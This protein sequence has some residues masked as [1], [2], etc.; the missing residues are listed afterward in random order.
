MCDS[1]LENLL[2]NHKLVIINKSQTCF[3]AV[4]TPVS[5]RLVLKMIHLLLY[6]FQHHGRI[7]WK[8]LKL[9]IL[10]MKV[11]MIQKAVGKRQRNPLANGAGLHHLNLNKLKRQLSCRQS[12]LLR[13]RYNTSFAVFFYYLVQTSNIS[14]AR[15]TEPYT[16]TDFKNL[17]VDSISQPLYI[18]VVGRL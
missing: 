17:P 5:T 7:Y 18:W 1:A 3:F 6:S 13:K 2:T 9:H 11:E 12:I 16:V 14:F 10:G 15:R 8:R 4:V